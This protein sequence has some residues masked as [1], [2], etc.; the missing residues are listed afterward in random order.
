MKQTIGYQNLDTISAYVNKLSDQEK[1][2]RIS[3]LDQTCLEKGLGFDLSSF[4][5]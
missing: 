2:E 4:N 3:Q 1:Q 5:S